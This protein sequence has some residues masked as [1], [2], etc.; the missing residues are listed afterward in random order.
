VPFPMQSLE[1][2]SIV[3]S[4]PPV[5]PHRVP[6]VTSPRTRA[7]TS[8]SSSRPPPRIGVESQPRTPRPS[9]T[10]DLGVKEGRRSLAVNGNTLDSDWMLKQLTQLQ[11]QSV[12]M[13]DRLETVAAENA[14]LRKNAGRSSEL[15]VCCLKAE[16]ADKS[17]EL[18]RSREAASQSEAT[19]AALYGER[20]RLEVRCAELEED[21]RAS[22]D[23]WM[24]ELVNEKRGAAL[25]AREVETKMVRADNSVLRQEVRRLSREVATL[26]S[27]LSSR[28]PEADVV[29][30]EREGRAAG[31]R[32]GAGRNELEPGNSALDRALE[33]R[34]SAAA[35]GGSARGIARASAG[36]A[37]A[38]ER[39][40]AGA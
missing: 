30:I 33:G 11:A 37:A 28:R 2:R 24:W 27:M 20:N 13:N 39:S 32:K 12:A 35:A 18:T 16:L 21:A 5:T 7:T 31:A 14:Q 9:T 3:P 22:A 36:A 6:V 26:S 1:A 34:P 29:V 4:F 19:L 23:K 40:G 17:S 8:Q 10:S 25:K 38:G 15:E